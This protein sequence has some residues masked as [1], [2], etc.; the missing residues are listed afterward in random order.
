MCVFPYTNYLEQS[1]RLLYTMVIIQN[2]APDRDDGA[3]GADRE[4]EQ[5]QGEGRQ[6]EVRHEGVYICHS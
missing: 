1:T 3:S 2:Q 4:D 6:G 5:G